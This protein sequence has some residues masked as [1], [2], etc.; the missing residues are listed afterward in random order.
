VKERFAEVVNYA[1][2]YNSEWTKN[3][4]LK[5]MIYCFLGGAMKEKRVR[6]KDFDLEGFIR[7]SV[8]KD[9]DDSEA[10]YFRFETLESRPDVRSD[11]SAGEIIKALKETKGFF[12][13]VFPEAISDDEYEEY[14]KSDSYRESM[15]DEGYEEERILDDEIMMTIGDAGLPGFLLHQEGEEIVINN[16]YIEQCGCMG[17][18]PKLEIAEDFGVFE[19]P[20]ERYLKKYIRK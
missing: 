3:V 14:K 6:N 1:G 10:G 17:P 7:N 12:F 13:F 16:G 4:E 5:F 20:M 19:K 8:L 18:M 2:D 9:D 15:E 11:K